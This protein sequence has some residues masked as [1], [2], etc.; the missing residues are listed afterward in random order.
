[1]ACRGGREI[2][3]T[4]VN[5]Y[6]E[7]RFSSLG[8]NGTELYI[9]EI[10][11]SDVYTTPYNYIHCLNL[12]DDNWTKGVGNSN[13]MLL[14]SDDAFNQACLTNAV[15]F[16]NHDGDVVEIEN[17]E[18][19]N[20]GYLHITLSDPAKAESF[21]YPNMYEIIRTTPET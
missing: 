10:T 8:G 1:M 13:G 14:L 18:S 4:V 19:S 20:N 6:G 7:V 11:T 2:P 21:A 15:A 3:V 12:T 17:I 9:D 16:K 5:G